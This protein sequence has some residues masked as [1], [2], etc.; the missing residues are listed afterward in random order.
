MNWNESEIREILSETFTTVC[1][2]FDY[3]NHY[4]D[5]FGELFELLAYPDSD[6]VYSFSYHV[7]KVDF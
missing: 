4:G 7:T 6:T 3:R 5:H 1:L 2:W